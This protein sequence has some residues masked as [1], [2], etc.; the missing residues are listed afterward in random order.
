M[1]KKPVFIPYHDKIVIEPVVQDTFLVSEKSPKRE[2]GKVIAVGNKV[3][4]VKTGDTLFFNP[5]GYFETG[6]VDGVKY[7]VIPENSEFIL[8]KFNGYKK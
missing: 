1:K 7:C 6:E 5:W 8:G 3:K 4:F 2:M